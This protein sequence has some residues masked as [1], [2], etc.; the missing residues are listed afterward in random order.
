MNRLRNS[1]SGTVYRKFIK[2]HPIYEFKVQDV[3]VW[4]KLKFT[5]I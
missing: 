2:S 4:Y 3:D 5:Y 1:V